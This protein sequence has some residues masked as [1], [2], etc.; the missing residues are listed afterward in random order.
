MTDDQVRSKT[1]G[2]EKVGER[3]GKSAGAAILESMGLYHCRSVTR[4][5][6]Q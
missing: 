1:K 6:Y 2:E 3:E 4:G 5:V